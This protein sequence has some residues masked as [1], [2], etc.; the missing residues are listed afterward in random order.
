M[1]SP[2]RSDMTLLGSRGPRDDEMLTDGALGIVRMLHHKF[3]DARRA[4]LLARETR[5]FGPDGPDFL[6]ETASVREDDTWRV[7]GA[8]P[9]LEDRRV[10]ITGPVDRKMTIN[11]MNSGARC[12]LADFEDATSPTWRNIVD[13]QVNL[14]DAVSR[15]I[16]HEENGKTYR[17]AADRELATIVVRPRGLHLDERHVRV[18]GRP[19]SAALF[20]FGVYL[21]HNAHRLVAQGLGPYFYLPKLESH[22]EARWWDDVF[23]CAERWAGLPHGTIRATVL[24]ETLPAAFEM[25]EILHELRDHAAGLNAGRWDYIF[26]T[27]KV[28][29]AERD[30]VLPD[31]TDVTMSVPHMRAYTE[32][33]VRT[34]HRR[35]AHAI[36]GMAALIPGRDPATNERAFAA[37]RADKDREAADGFDGSW[38]A[39]PGLVATCD[40]A[41][42]AVLGDHPHQLDR[43]REDVDVAAGDLLATG[44]TGGAVTAS[45]LRTNVAVL[46]GYLS[47]WLEGRGAVAINGLMEDAATAEISRCQI[48]QWIRHEVPIDDGGVVTRRLVG[49]V[50]ERELIPYA[51]EEGI[52]SAEADART[53]VLRDL[54]VR[55]A[56]AEDLPPFLTSIA[57]AE[58]LVEAAAR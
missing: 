5:T 10:E 43:T 3:D 38:V 11:A 20:D 42:S 46:L 8:G 21:H 57:Y 16:E 24:I 31:R 17:L 9:G 25:E 51:L 1:C 29:G 58:H 54:V 6:P 40:D 53:S 27:I 7:A 45:G 26:S 39:H 4:L 12:W 49:D 56:L 35:G 48:W 22:L 14:H 55:T 23:T 19:V 34:C 52:G 44:K 47:S 13:G 2:T 18:N 41:F 28:L 33:L 32:L 37:V 36:G 30:H 15:V 50:L